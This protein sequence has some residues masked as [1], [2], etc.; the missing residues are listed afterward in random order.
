MGP[1]PVNYEI[2]RFSFTLVQKRPVNSIFVEDFSR[3]SV[4]FLVQ[5]KPYVSSQNFS[6][7][8]ESGS[9]FFKKAMRSDDGIITPAGVQKLM[10]WKM[11]AI[12]QG[13]IL[14]V[15]KTPEIYGGIH[16]ITRSIYIASYFLIYK[17]WINVGREKLCRAEWQKR[18]RGGG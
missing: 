7:G 2:W 17:P 1:M 10:L 11:Y 14:L 5:V 3:H 18:E 15:T 9:L 6:L 8:K 16:S 4:F 13:K 12:T